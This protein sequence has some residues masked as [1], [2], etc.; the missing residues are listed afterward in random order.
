MERFERICTNISFGRSITERI[1]DA[2]LSILRLEPYLDY[3]ILYDAAYQCPSNVDSQPL[4]K[5]SDDTH[6]EFKLLPSGSSCGDDSYHAMVPDGLKSIELLEIQGVIF[7]YGKDHKTPCS[8][9]K[10]P[11]NIIL[12]AML[13]NFCRVI[14]DHHKNH[15][16]FQPLTSRDFGCSI[17]SFPWE[18]CYFQAIVDWDV[19][20]IYNLMKAYTA[21]MFNPRNPVSGRN[22]RAREKG[23][24]RTNNGHL[25][26]LNPLRMSG[27]LNPNTNSHSP[28]PYPYGALKAVEHCSYHSSAEK[29]RPR[30]NGQT[31]TENEACRIQKPIDGQMG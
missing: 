31:R 6:N 18:Q 25:E 14:S 4:K 29:N 19:C 9:L 22:K 5:R 23:Q 12:I 3:K 7:D 16:R 1:Y 11:S 8:A 27:S 20:G 10:K 24:T 30:D 28:A 21:D 17:I 15:E 26:Y 13:T 2:R